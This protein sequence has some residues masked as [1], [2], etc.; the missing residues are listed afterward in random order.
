MA[1]H[2]AVN[3][4]LEAGQGAGTLGLHGGLHTTSMDGKQHILRVLLQ[5]YLLHL[6][7]FGRAMSMLW[8]QP[9]YFPADCPVHLSARTAPTSSRHGAPGPYTSLQSTDSSQ[10]TPVCTHR[11]PQEE[12]ENSAVVTL[13][14]AHTSATFRLADR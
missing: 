12:A 8:H 13:P 14:H 5:F 9:G 1:E 2:P 11:A 10:N 6:C 3:L 7:S 4:T